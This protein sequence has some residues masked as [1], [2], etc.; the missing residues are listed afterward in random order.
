MTNSQPTR[1]WPERL[2]AVLAATPASGPS[3]SIDRFAVG[4]DAEDGDPARVKKGIV[5]FLPW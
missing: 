3:A 1:D 5:N 4:D 2:A